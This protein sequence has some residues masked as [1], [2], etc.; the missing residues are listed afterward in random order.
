MDLPLT[1]DPPDSLGFAKVSGL[2]GPGTWAAWFL[3]V[4]AS[5]IHIFFHS[6]RGKKKLDL[7]LWVYPLDSMSRHSTLSAALV[8]YANYTMRIPRMGNGKK[9]S[10]ASG[11]R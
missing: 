11:Q 5:W 3:T 4:A 10:R 2:Y 8:S 9:R 1:V 6:P 7:N